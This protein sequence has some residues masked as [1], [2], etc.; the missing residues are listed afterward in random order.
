MPGTVP[1]Y[2]R[3]VG[4]ALIV[5]SAAC[6]SPSRDPSPPDA[7]PRSSFTIADSLRE[8]EHYAE[9]L[10]RYRRLSGSL[11]A[12]G[13]SAQWWKA[14]LWWSY[15]QMRL[16]QLDSAGERLERAKLLV[17][18]DLDRRAWTH[19]VSSNLLSLQGRFDS[20]VVEAERGRDLARQTQ[21]EY[22]V[23]AVAYALGW[24]YSSTGRAAEAFAVDSQ[25]L[26]RRR[27]R[28][29]EPRLAL[30]AALNAV[31]IDYYWMGRD[32]DA[33]A[34]L[35]EALS[36][37]RPLGQLHGATRALVTLGHLYDRNSD[38]PRAL[39]A[40]TEAL[41]YAE[42]IG[43][44]SN[45][46][47]ILHNNIAVL[48]QEHGNWPAAR[49]HLQQALQIA[50]A[51]GQPYAE[52]LALLN[53]G[54]IENFE[55]RSARAKPFL[56]AALALADSLGHVV[57]AHGVRTELTYSLIDLGE[58]G[59]A[60]ELSAAA[61]RAA[62]SVATPVLQV[63]A[64]EARGFA[65]ERAGKIKQAVAHYLRAME[66]VES[67]RGRVA[68]GDLRMGPGHLYR[69][70]Y[71]RTVALFVRLNR[72]E[73]AFEIVERARARL[74][75]DLMAS[76]QSSPDDR[77]MASLQKELKDRL[78]AREDAP[79]PDRP[80]LDRAIARTS[81]ALGQL[82][83]EARK[84]D[85][86]AGAARYPSPAAFAHIRDGL[87]DR[88]RAILAFYWGDREVF[89]WWISA[90][91]IRGIRLGASD[92]LGPAVE[93]LRGTLE[94]G[95][96]DSSWMAPARRVYQQLIVPLQPQP[97]TEVVVLA[98]G[99]LAHIPVEALLPPGES[100]PWGHGRRFRYGPSASV[101]LALRQTSE[102]GGS[103]RAILALGNPSIGRGR[104][105][106]SLRS[107]RDIDPG[108]LP[109]AATEA[110][111]IQQLFRDDGA[112]L[113]VGR[114]ASLRRWLQLDPGRYRYLHFAAHARVNDSRP[115]RTHLLLYQ[116]VLGL[117]GIK[118]LR[119]RADLVTLSACETALGRQLRG[120]GVIGLPHAFLAAGARAVLVTLWRVGDRS[121]ADFMTQFYSELRTGQAPAEALQSV[122]RRW[123]ETGGDS[124]HPS[125][126]APFILVGGLSD[127]R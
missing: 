125:R 111:A 115:D 84:R 92:T 91:T 55:G 24:V 94:S 6:G 45:E 14:E 67:W 80:Q 77:R 28:G 88:D 75:L 99:P 29:G 121:A 39:D 101:L 22:L 17:G 12:A 78:S 23:H 7:Q 34:A 110:A 120:E 105:A 10:P 73:Q 21:D 87:L 123:I 5:G 52:I 76:G 18:S 124:A 42:R 13:D 53:L 112:D 51:T 19:I 41:G 90:D 35:E 119:L 63:S 81:S 85:P 113:L 33:A 47:A 126:W 64:L 69:S 72:P 70:G 61:L 102:G 108:P 50:R 79:S 74:L 1:D 48:L 54:R 20:A 62:D 32:T 31:G 122:R 89:G 114:Q 8:L 30:A 57:A 46:V 59:T 66:L 25:S 49:T 95:P 109:H 82:E 103:S 36:I 127:G 71:E 117:A 15:S 116:S 107:A 98:D 104:V 97:A 37:Y 43:R 93:F 3:C 65:L 56:T 58:R 68:L 44:Q 2:Y 16:G 27:A 11:A 38:E 26:A 118:R 100:V 9:A 86:A 60:L 4:L 96:G 83:L 106:D 40:Y